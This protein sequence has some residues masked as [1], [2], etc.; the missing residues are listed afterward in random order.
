MF[1]K[2]ALISWLKRR[3]GALIGPVFAPLQEETPVL[4]LVWLPRNGVRHGERAMAAV[5]QMG[6]ID[7]ATVDAAAA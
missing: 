6:R 3:A 4:R 7:I 5:M 1:S 2:R